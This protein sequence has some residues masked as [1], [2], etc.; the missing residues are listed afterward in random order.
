MS[1]IILVEIIINA[2][3]PNGCERIDASIFPLNKYVIEFPNPQPGQKL[4]PKLE[5]GQI[6]KFEASGELI[7]IK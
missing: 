5:I 3:I 4:N 6:V 7:K 2:T 1:E